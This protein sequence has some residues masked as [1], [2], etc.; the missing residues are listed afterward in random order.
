MPRRL[1]IHRCGKT[2]TCAVTAERDVHLPSASAAERWR[3]WMQ[4]GPLQV[5]GGRCGFEVR[6]AVHAIIKDGYHL[7][8][9]STSILGKPGAGRFKVPGGEAPD[10]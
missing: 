3:F 7:F 9:G 10:A 5:Q 2:D 6:T 1:Y 8:T 4:V